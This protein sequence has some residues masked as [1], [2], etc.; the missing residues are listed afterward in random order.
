MSGNL[1]QASEQLMRAS[2]DARAWVQETAATAPSV[3]N[4]SHSLVGAA[5]RAANLGRKL[6]G[7]AG[8]R[9]CVGVFGPSQAGKSYLVSALARRPGGSLIRSAERRVG[10]ECGSTCRS[11]WSPSD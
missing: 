10:K 1:R 6:S 7:A 11:R 8:R 2:L 3:A 5:R 9:A 4:Q